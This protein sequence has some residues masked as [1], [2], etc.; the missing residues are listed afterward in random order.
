MTKNNQI[1][2]WEDLPPA[3]SSAET[4]ALI[5][6]GS[7]ESLEK[8]VLGNLRL[9]RAIVSRRVENL[10]QGDISIASQ[11]DLEEECVFVLMK[12]VR[13]FDPDRGIAFSTFVSHGILNI[14]AMEYRRQNSRPKSISL[15]DKIKGSGRRDEDGVAVCETLSDA[16]FTNDKFED[17]LDSL[18]INT[19]VIP[20]LSRMEREIFIDYYKNEKSRE[21]IAIKNNMVR[22]NVTRYLKKAMQ[23][24][25]RMAEHGIS[26]EDLALRK[27][28][29][30]SGCMGEF[31]RKRAILKKYGEDFLRKRFLYKLTPAQATIFK[32]AFLNFYGQQK[33]LISI[34]TGYRTNYI[35]KESEKIYKILQETEKELLKEKEEFDKLPILKEPSKNVRM[36]Q[37]LVEKHG[38]KAFL[39]KYFVPILKKDDKKLFITRILNYDGSLSDSEIAKSLEMT[40][41]SF[42][43]NT[44]RLVDKMENMDFELLNELIDNSLQRNYE[45]DID[46]DKVKERKQ[47]L[48]RHG[49]KTDIIKQF[50]PT[51]VDKEKK[52]LEDFYLFPIYIR[53]EDYEKQQGWEAGSFKATENSI[54]AKLEDFNFEKDQKGSRRTQGAPKTAEKS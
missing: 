29:L 6:E 14:L 31:E 34:E 22:T 50:K 19:K 15:D 5:R 37:M 42:R 35:E 9:V 10:Q 53:D 18:F 48:Q 4:C 38:G 49:A 16:D 17:I 23:K 39:W 27:I 41:K 54:R 1:N 46:L 26:E 33:K 32:S 28:S 44:L 13:C 3:L 45:F 24:V 52:L 8:A 40:P 2:L 25:K 36:A 20:L 47:F 43:K 51:L 12:C 21:E 7:E 30:G 11:E